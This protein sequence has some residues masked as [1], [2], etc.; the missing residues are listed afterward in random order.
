MERTLDGLKEIPSVLLEPMRY[1]LF[2]LLNKNWHSLGGSNQRKFRRK[3]ALLYF[4]H[5]DLLA[6]YLL[7]DSRLV[8]DQAVCYDQ[9]VAK[10]ANRILHP[11]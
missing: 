7:A 2:E 8:S 10:I 9:N 5:N 4:D 3:G 1:Q 11:M 6:L